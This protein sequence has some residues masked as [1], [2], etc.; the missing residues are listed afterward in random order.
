MILITTSVK[1]FHFRK[2]FGTSATTETMNSCVKCYT[3]TGHL[4]K[5]KNPE[6]WTLMDSVLSTE[7]DRSIQQHCLCR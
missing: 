6:K 4:I 1:R 5:E 2:S 3:V 7:E